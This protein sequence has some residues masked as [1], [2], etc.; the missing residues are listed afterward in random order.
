MLELSMKKMESIITLQ[1]LQTFICK[2][3][4]NS[5]IDANRQTMV[6]QDI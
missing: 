3:N 5:I 6:I 1:M 2:V 4:L